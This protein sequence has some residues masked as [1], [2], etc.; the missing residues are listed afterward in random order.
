[1]AYKRKPL[2]KPIKRHG[3]TYEWI[4]G[5]CGKSLVFSINGIKQGMCDYCGVWID[6]ESVNEKDG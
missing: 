1:M 6:W 5:R 3:I 4:C 2:R